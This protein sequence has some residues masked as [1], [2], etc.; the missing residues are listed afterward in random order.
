MIPEATDSRK[1]PQGPACRFWGTDGGCKKGSSC[2]Y[3]HAWDG[4]EKT[5]RCF[6]CS[7]M[8]HSKRDCPVKKPMTGSPWKQPAP[9]VSKVKKP[10]D[11]KMPAEGQAVGGEGGGGVPRAT[12]RNPGADSSASRATG[13]Q[14]RPPPGGSEEASGLLKSLRSIRALQIKCAAAEKEAGE[15]G[16]VQPVALLDGG[17]T[18]ALR[19]ARP[20]ER[21]NLTAVEVELACGS[22]VLYKHAG[23][24][25]ILTLEPVEPIIPLRMLVDAGFVVRWNAKGCML[26]HPAT[27]GCT[28]GCGMAVRSCGGQRR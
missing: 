25:A 16:E 13:E 21:D 4:L 22:T 24:S 14:A 15:I 5:N 23:T 11:E 10:G 17:A 26:E 1:K 2:T 20:H 6:A 18:H 27:E 12:G 7:G 3:A 19:Q 8:G 28:A 9:K